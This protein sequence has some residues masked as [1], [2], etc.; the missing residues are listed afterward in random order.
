[1]LIFATAMAQLRFS[2]LMAVYEEGNRENGALRYPRCSAQEQCL[3]AEQDF[4]AY[5]SQVFF[6]TPGA[7]Y[8]LWEEDGAYRSALRLEP[9]RDA[10]LLEALETAPRWRAQGYGG[11]LVR[12][13]Q[14]ALSAR[15]GARLYSHVARRN[16]AS[17]ALHTG[18]GFREILPYAAYIDGTVS[19]AA[20]TLLWE[21]AGAD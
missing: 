12:A 13:V 20:V 17:V 10:L 15:G 2:E 4:F 3:R 9:Y 18:C 6:R 7:A 11:K 1:M 19:F 21:G 14:A 16:A 5:L 8:A